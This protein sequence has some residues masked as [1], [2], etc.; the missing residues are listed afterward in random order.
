MAYWI[1]KL[2]EQKLY[3]DIHGKKYVFDNTHSVRVQANDVFLYLDKRV[4]YSFTA[5]GLIKKVDKRNP[6][7]AEAERT[8]KVRTIFEAYLS[9][10]IWFEKP[11]SIS[12]QVKI[13][14]RNRA[15]LGIVDLN[16]LGWSQ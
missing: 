11:L 16:L 9:D 10:L 2:A 8:S 5:I 7:A 12:P 6:T 14:R 15:K 4:G 1:F 3:P 13:G